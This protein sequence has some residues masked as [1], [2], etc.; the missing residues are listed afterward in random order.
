MDEVADKQ[1]LKPGNSNKNPSKPKV[2][3][4]DAIE[5]EEEKKKSEG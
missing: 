1:N 2:D 4:L 3:R 5:E